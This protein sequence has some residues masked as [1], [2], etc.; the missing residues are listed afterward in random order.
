MAV[1]GLMGVL[2]SDQ[3]LNLDASGVPAFFFQ[4]LLQ[5]AGDNTQDVFVR[6]QDRHFLHETVDPPKS[7]SQ[8]AEQLVGV[9][10][11]DTFNSQEIDCN[12]IAR[13]EGRDDIMA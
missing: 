4:S 10:L 1:F 12:G 7:Y 5:S 3:R 13:A 11:G 6:V 9:R 8:H 2:R